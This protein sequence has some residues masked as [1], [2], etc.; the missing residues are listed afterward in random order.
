MKHKHL[1]IT[2]LSVSAFAVGCK[3]SEEKST[4]Q[5]LEKVKTETQAAAA[6]MKDYTFAQKN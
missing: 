4:S 1:V 6:D 2:Y 5:Q 3:P